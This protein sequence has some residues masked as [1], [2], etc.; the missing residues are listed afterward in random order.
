MSRYLS[1]LSLLLHKNRQTTPKRNF[2][3]NCQVVSNLDTMGLRDIKTCILHLL[4]FHQVLNVTL[5][6]NLVSDL[7]PTD[8]SYFYKTDKNNYVP[9]RK[10]SEGLISICIW[11]VILFTNKIWDTLNSLLST[12]DQNLPTISGKIYQMMV[13]SSSWTKTLSKLQQSL[14]FFMASNTLQLNFSHIIKKLPRTC[15][16][17]V[18]VFIVTGWFVENLGNRNFFFGHICFP[19]YFWSPKLGSA[20][21]SSVSFRFW[22][23]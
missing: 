22:W 8:K 11:K 14:D 9:T 7:E 6:T 3:L 13:I 16:V 20:D 17:T 23:I 19:S 1:F 4:C 5:S 12:I 2:S 10:T 15:C 18:A 21:A